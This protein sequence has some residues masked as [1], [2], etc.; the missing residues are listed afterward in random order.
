[1]KLCLLYLTVALMVATG[2]LRL[3]RMRTHHTL[4]RV[5]RPLCMRAC[6][7]QP[8]KGSCNT[9]TLTPLITPHN[10]SLKTAPHTAS[11]AAANRK[12]L[13]IRG[14]FVPTPQSAASR[15]AATITQNQIR[16]AVDA[17]VPN[18]YATQAATATGQVTA[19]L[20]TWSPCSLAPWAPGCP[21]WDTWSPITWNGRRRRL[22]QIRGPFIPNQQ[23]VASR[24]AAAITQNQI[25]AAVN[26]P[27]PN[28]YSTQ[29]AT[30][31]GQVTADLA[32]WSP[33][34]LAPYGPGCWNGWNNWGWVGRH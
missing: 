10:P 5:A 24:T 22:Q 8:A 15:T 33:C 19:D 23:A 6:A 9:N 26:N 30:A 3:E 11:A 1:M 7:R 25:R 2:A 34:T 4:A 18:F 20:A 16:A 21:Q 31:T 32:T 29:A 28:F 13:Q 17:P 12:L 14:P 27:V